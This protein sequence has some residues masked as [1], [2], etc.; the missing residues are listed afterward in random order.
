MIEL[1]VNQMLSSN[2]HIAF[3]RINIKKIIGLMV[4]CNKHIMYQ[5]PNSFSSIS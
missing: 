4:V 2:Q 5:S 1:L 3:T